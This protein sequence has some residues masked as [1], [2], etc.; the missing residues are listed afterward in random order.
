[1]LIRS[2]VPST[3]RNSLTIWVLLNIWKL[4]NIQKLFVTCIHLTHIGSCE[5]VENKIG[6]GFYLRRINKNYL[7]LFEQ[8]KNWIKL[9]L[10]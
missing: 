9:E 10:W 4:F 8:L 6:F 7:R 3:I 2:P 5:E 1:M